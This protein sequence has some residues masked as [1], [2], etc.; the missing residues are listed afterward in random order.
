[1]SSLSRAVSHYLL[2]ASNHPPEHFG[3]VVVVLHGVLDEAEAVDVTDEGVAVG[4]QQVEAAHRLLQTGS[5]SLV[6][7][8]IH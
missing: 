7:E 4:S 5:S 2:A 1:M 8:C 6:T 3:A